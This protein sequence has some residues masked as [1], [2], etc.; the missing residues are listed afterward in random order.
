MR[1]CILANSVAFKIRPRLQRPERLTYVEHLRDAGV[2][3]RAVEATIEL[4][5]TTGA[6]A[7]RS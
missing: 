7:C 4:P 6:V 1:I 2:N 3:V 5:L